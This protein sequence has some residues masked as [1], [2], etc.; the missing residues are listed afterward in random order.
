MLVTNISEFDP[1][2]LR[3]LKKMTFEFFGLRITLA[4]DISFL[5]ASR[6]SWLSMT[7]RGLIFML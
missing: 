1:S 3:V 7:E 6:I 5:A 2:D 4:I